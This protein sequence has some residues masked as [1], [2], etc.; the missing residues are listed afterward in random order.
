M[1][2]FDGKYVQMAWKHQLVDVVAGKGVLVQFD[3]LKRQ[4]C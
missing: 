1:I 2:Q 3:L 4:E